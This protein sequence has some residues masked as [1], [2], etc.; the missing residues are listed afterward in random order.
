[1]IVKNLKENLTNTHYV[2]YTK[3]YKIYLA[4]VSQ[5]NSKPEEQ[6]DLLMI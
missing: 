6:V 2:L 4:Y 3:N 5:Y 1:M